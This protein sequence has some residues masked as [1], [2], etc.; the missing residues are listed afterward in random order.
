[1]PEHTE[2]NAQPVEDSEPVTDVKPAST[3]E[4][5]SLPMTADDIAR[6]DPRLGAAMASGLPLDDADL[7]DEEEMD[8]GFVAVD[9]DQDDSSD[10][11]QWFLRPPV[12][13]QRTQLDDLHPFVQVLSVSNAD[14]CVQVEDA[15]PEAERCSREKVWN[16]CL[17]EKDRLG[18]N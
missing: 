15:L 3:V 11:S 17:W 18:I 9:H 1:M 8:E 14:D 12:Q 13:H 4:E 7:D 5:Y 10:F 6:M 16:Q 2:N